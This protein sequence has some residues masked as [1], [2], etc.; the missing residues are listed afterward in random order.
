[1]NEA[2]FVFAKADSLVEVPYVETSFL[3]ILHV[4]SMISWS[5]GI[6]MNDM[7]NVMFYIQYVICYVL[8]VMC[9]VQYDKYDD[10]CYFHGMTFLIQIWKVLSL[11]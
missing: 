11:S 4:K 7:K 2:D 8:D 9:C 1:M 6:Q 5:Q 10:T 3:G